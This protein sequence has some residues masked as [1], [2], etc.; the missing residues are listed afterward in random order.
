MRRK[1]RILLEKWRRERHKRLPLLAHSQEERNRIGKEERLN[2]SLS[3][4]FDSFTEQEHLPYNAQDMVVIGGKYPQV[5]N[6]LMPRVVRINGPQI[7]GDLDNTVFPELV[8][9]LDRKG[10]TRKYTNRYS[11]GMDLHALAHHYLIGGSREHYETIV[12][13]SDRC[14]KIIGEYHKQQPIEVGWARGTKWWT[15]ICAVCYHLHQKNIFLGACDIDTIWISD[16]YDQMH[17]EDPKDY[18]KKYLKQ[19][20]WRKPWWKKAMTELFHTKPIDIPVLLE[21]RYKRIPRPFKEALLEIWELIQKWEDHNEDIQTL[22]QNGKIDWTYE[23]SVHPIHWHNDGRD[24]GEWIRRDV[25]DAVNNLVVVNQIVTRTVVG[26]TVTQQ[27]IGDPIDK[28]YETR[29]AIKACL[30][31]IMEHQELSKK[32]SKKVF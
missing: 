24:L 29:K 26:G 18:P 32:R 3:S 28:K 27:T 20:E 30:D 6:L 19:Q 23:S 11:N 7:D 13:D 22:L 21:G 2:S 4:W 16:H 31:M 12:I 10:I 25:N 9:V 1:T 14:M 15:L 17:F 5:T 8:E